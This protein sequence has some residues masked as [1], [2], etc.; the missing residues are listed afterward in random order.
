MKKYAIT[1]VTKEDCESL[2]FDI[3]MLTDKDMQDIADNLG[4]SYLNG[5]GEFWSD[6]ES[7]LI[8]VYKLEQ[9]DI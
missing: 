4:Q 7:I 5:N 2:G 6:L 1:Y 8:E 3:S 9:K